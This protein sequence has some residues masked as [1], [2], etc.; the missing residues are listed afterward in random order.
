MEGK[1]MVNQIHYSDAESRTRDCLQLWVGLK[2]LKEAVFSTPHPITCLVPD[3][4]LK[5]SSA[6]RISLK[7]K[8]LQE[9]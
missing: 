8:I 1:K 4:D 2:A 3:F 9:G 5:L 6:V 7:K